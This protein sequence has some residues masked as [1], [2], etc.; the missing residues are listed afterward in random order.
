MVLNA[1]LGVLEAYYSRSLAL[2]RIDYLK[3]K[4]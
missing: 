2:D 4:I 1:K 3:G